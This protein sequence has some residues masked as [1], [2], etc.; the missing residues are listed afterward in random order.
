M[1]RF[2]IGLSVLAPILSKAF[3]KN[4]FARRFQIFGWHSVDRPAGVLKFAALLWILAVRNLGSHSVLSQT[5]ATIGE[6][7]TPKS[8]HIRIRSF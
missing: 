7:E 5:E 6:A 3:V 8:R 2:F 1:N 4:L